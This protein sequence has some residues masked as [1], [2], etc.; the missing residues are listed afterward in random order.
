MPTEPA[1]ILLVDDDEPTRDATSECLT[2]A[3]F[4]VRVASN[5]QD[6][7][8]MLA[9]LRPDLLIVDW[10]MPVMSGE[11][12]LA[13]V[14]ADASLAT[15]PALVLSGLRAEEIAVPNAT[16]LQKPLRMAALLGAVR[17]RLRSPG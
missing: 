4:D 6:A 2:H 8:D 13:S 9:T 7:L 14:R 17:E 1:V 10:R 3:G 11:E 5:G 12:L 16:I 15:I